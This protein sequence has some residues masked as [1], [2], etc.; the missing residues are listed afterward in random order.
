MQNAVS[1][2]DRR[3]GPGRERLHHIQ[4][5]RLADDQVT[6]IHSI[7]P[8]VFIVTLGKYMTVKLR[9]KS[10]K[11]SG[12]IDKYYVLVKVDVSKDP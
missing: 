2:A 11:H 10:E 4:R 1:G 12:E 7:N 5:V 6:I 9:M 8:I 3:G